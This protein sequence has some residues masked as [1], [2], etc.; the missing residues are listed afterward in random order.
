MRSR[1]LA[2]LAVV[3]AAGAMVALLLL[4]PFG[5][6][7]A[8]DDRSEADGST[9][10]PLGTGPDDRGG[11]D[12]PQRPR[13]SMPDF[14]SRGPG[15]VRVRVLGLPS[16]APLPDVALR[17]VRGTGEAVEART[18][19]DGVVL[20]SEVPAG[21]ALR[22]EVEAPKYPPVVVQGID[23]YAGRTTALDDLLLGSRVVLAGRVV[24][25]RGKGIPDA[26]VSAFSS[27]G[28]DV[29]A[30][31]LESIVT[32]ALRFPSAADEA[33]TDAEG[34]FALSALTPGRYRLS[35]RRGGFATNHQS[36]LVVAP[37]RP[38]GAVTIV[39]G[40]PARVLGRVSDEDGR[41]VV[42]ASV[43]AIEAPEQRGSRADATTRKDVATT[44]ADGRYVLD[45]LALGSSYRFGVV[46]TGW[47]PVFEVAPT[48]LDPEQERD[49]VLA[50]GGAVEGFVAS[51]Q[52]DAPV[53]GARV[54]V[55]VG[56]LGSFLGGGRRGGGAAGGGGGGAA[57][58]GAATTGPDG[59]FR[60]E[61]LRPGPVLSAQVKAAGFAPFSA[62]TFTQ[63]P[64]GDV[65]AGESLAVEARLAPGG[66]VEGRVTAAEGGA[67]IAG[68]QVLAMSRSPVAMWVGHPTAVAD[69]TGAFRVEGI[70]TDSRF[71]LVATAPGYAPGDPQDESLQMSMPADGGTLERD[72]SLAAAGAVEGVVVT[73][74]GAPVAGVRVRTRS[75]GGG[76]GFGAMFGRGGLRDL[77]QG[78]GTVVLTDEQGRYRIEGVATQGRLVVEASSD[79][80]VT[81]DS[82][83]FD[84]RPAAVARVDVTLLGP[85]TLRGR[86][87]D[88]GGRAVAGARV[89][90]GALEGNDATRRNLQSFRADALL[91]PRATAVSDADGRFEVGRL[92]PGPTLLKVERE[93]FV[94][95]YRRDLHVEPDAAIEG[96]VV[97][98]S[99]GESVAGLV[100]GEDGRPVPGARVF[101]S[102]A[103]PAP[104]APGAAGT[105]ADPAGA[106]EPT[107]AAV[108]DDRGRFEV[109]NVPSGGP[110]QVAVGMAPGY[111]GWWGTSDPA[112]IRRDVP[113]GERNVEFTLKRAEPGDAA[114]FGGG[115]RPPVPAGMSGGP[116]PGPGPAMGAR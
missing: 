70:P 79:D 72:L 4:D 41:P 80:V 60:I 78:G 94:T 75:D 15:A 113:P 38:T 37:D 98:L 59:R 26:V 9:L 74:R 107:L 115:M 14:E 22:L 28:F 6:G 23:V 5:S 88:E 50:R 102:R 84:V 31:I 43:L 85:A 67:P 100:R 30:G 17:L 73:S 58:T 112:A 103:G 52:G 24:D 13:L 63:N 96:Y 46:A 104:A 71:S 18:G 99:R 49:F 19:P 65:V 21:L 35:A 32:E 8:E 87:V 83:P 16:R 61:G 7:T 116:A 47:A 86:V 45:T 90:A 1:S 97:T 12:E 91:D 36:D 110:L 92:R 2:V 81:T 66:A 95:F 39:L 76:R 56:N 54:T 20:F 89:R 105:P 69:S 57:S 108:T 109:E 33:R 44:G 77:L 42:G 62:S 25:E 114:A 106:V 10:A 11:T 101:V 51:A 34:R 48:T 29:G 93:G 55:I 68:A 111:R 64:W 53:E 27:A 82:E 3:L 40:P